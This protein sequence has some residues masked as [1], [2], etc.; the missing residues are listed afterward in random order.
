MFF[1]SEKCR[2]QFLV[3]GSLAYNE[4]NGVKANLSQVQ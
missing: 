3:L 4:V 1:H 2:G